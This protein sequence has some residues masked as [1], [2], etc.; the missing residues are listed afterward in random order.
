[1]V[2]DKRMAF[3]TK[4]AKN[5]AMLKT[6]EEREAALLAVKPESREFVAMTVRARLS[7]KQVAS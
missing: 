5:I 6:E 2:I 4:I 7:A 3:T 1:M